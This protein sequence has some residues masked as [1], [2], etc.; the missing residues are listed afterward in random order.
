[1]EACAAFLTF[2][3]NKLCGEVHL[4]MC[5]MLQKWTYIQ[6]LPALCFSVTG[7]RTPVSRVT[8]GDTS[9]YTMTDCF[10]AH[11]YTN[12]TYMHTS[13]TSISYTYFLSS[14]LYAQFLLITY[15]LITLNMYL[16][17]TSAQRC[18]HLSFLWP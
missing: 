9:H 2:W 4:Q 6:N 17:S 1:M 3:F 7:N 8:G 16:L 11:L 18:T 13:F 12:N 14:A 5:G 15:R 10:C